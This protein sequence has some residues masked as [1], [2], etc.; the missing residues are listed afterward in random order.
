MFLYWEQALFPYWE[1]MGSLSRNQANLLPSHNE[2]EQ[3]AGALDCFDKLVRTVRIQS[4]T[5]HHYFTHAYVR[6]L[7]RLVSYSLTAP[8][9]RRNVADA[10]SGFGFARS[11]NE[12]AASLR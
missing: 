4:A 5:D 10:P 3:L 12:M 7:P 8:W 6:G 11:K 2:I 9:G 1:L